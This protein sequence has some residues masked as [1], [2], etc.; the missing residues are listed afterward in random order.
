MQISNEEFRQKPLRVHNFLADVPLH[1]LWV[2]ELPGGGEGRTLSDFQQILTFGDLERANP[3]VGGLFRLRWMLGRLFGW[4]GAKH[5]LP[6]S[7]YVNRLTDTDRQH[8]L[9]EP[10]MADGPFR[11]IYRFE[12]EALGEI[13]NAT[14]HAFALTAMEQTAD[15]YRLYL[16][17][18]VKNVSP[19]TPF[20]MALIDPFRKLI[21]YPAMIRKME[22]TWASA[23][24]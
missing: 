8:T 5:D 4:D 15:G 6:A 20:Y 1:D 17:V 22:R 2:I 16:G 23:Y 19:M 24:V 13:I 18:Y 9:D 11:R 14:V 21:V 10:G 3:I 12:N 7:S